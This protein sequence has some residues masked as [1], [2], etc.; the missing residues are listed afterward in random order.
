MDHINRVNYGIVMF[1][2]SSEIMKCMLLKTAFRS[3]AMGVSGMAS[4][5]TM[6]VQLQ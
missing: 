2:W 5:I 3:C 6:V 1:F 4:L